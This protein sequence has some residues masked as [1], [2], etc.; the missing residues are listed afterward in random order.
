[1]KT[2][3]NILGQL[4]IY[5]LVDLALLIYVAGGRGQ[6]FWGVILLWIGFLAYLEAQHKHSY[7]VKIPQALWVIFLIV[8]L[9]L[10]K[11]IE[12]IGFIIAS[13]FYTRKD[14]ENYGIFAPFF[15]GLQNLLLVGGI[16]GFDNVLTWLVLY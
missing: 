13:Y 12:G 3:L 10:F 8:G 4:R 7:R 6:I 14:H 16:A 9:V 11:R 15:R 1:M 5:T 2:V